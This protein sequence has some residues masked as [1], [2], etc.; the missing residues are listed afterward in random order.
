MKK[1]KYIPIIIIITVLLFS[2]IGLYC[3]YPTINKNAKE[4]NHKLSI[5]QFIYEQTSKYNYVIDKQLKN[6]DYQ[7]YLQI[8]GNK[9]KYLQ[10]QEKSII[11]DFQ[12]Y[13]IEL[14]NEKNIYYYAI[15]TK[16]NKIINNT[17]DHLIDIQTDQKLQD[18]YQYYLQIHFDEYGDISL[19]FQ[20][21]S[22]ENNFSDYEAIYSD[23]YVDNDDEGETQ[24]ELSISKPKNITIT[25]AIPF[26]L[27]HNDTIDQYL[28]SSY[29][30]QSMIYMI[31]YIM[32]CLVIVVLT[33]LLIPFHKIKDNQFFHFISEIKF[34]ILSIIWIFIMYILSYILYDFINLT[35]SNE[36][37]EFYKVFAIEYMASY[38]TALINI[39]LWFIFFMLIAILIYMIK[40]LF[41]KGL[42]TYFL[43]NTCVSWVFKQIKRLINDILH[44]NFEDGTNKILLKIIIFNF[45]LICIISLLFVTGPMIA[46]IDSIII[47]FILKKK[48]EETK[49]DYQI[50][51]NA[52]KQLSNGHFDFEINEDI[53]MF[54]PLKNEFSHIKDGFEKAVSEEVKSQKM[55]TEL[56]SNVSHDLKTPLTSIITYVDLL[57]D[58]QISNQQRH[59]YIHILE[60]NSLRL[61]NLIEDL[62]EVS[63]AN[64]GNV[65]LDLIDVDIV[66]MIK[67][68]ELEYNEQFSEM[69]L[70][71]RSHYSNNKIICNLDSSKTY[72]IIENLFTNITKYA[73]KN[74][75]VYIDILDNDDYVEIVF[76]NISKDEMTFNESE[77]VE[78]FIQGDKSRN[79]SGSG[80]G[81]AIVKSFTEIQGGIF[82]VEIDGD[83]F[84]SIIKFKK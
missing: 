82:K 4:E 52:T 68:I 44:F 74:T 16:S 20:S 35:M 30:H 53:G 64:S 47:F 14:A 61:K 40:Y 59:E 56:I 19:K 26:E 60:R 33:I 51:L 58:E 31:P 25:Y 32:I 41:H 36:I 10:Q 37:Q 12:S 5:Y 66:A 13:E 67:Q 69:G 62:F 34:E 83:L 46:L 42:K 57:K 49:D 63:K 71:I 22:F 6:N 24:G 17:S 2:S 23:T 84:K 38:L 43:E 78:R 1:N 15:D 18:Q 7:Q 76:K 11:K 27:T 3:M 80:L 54:N 73:L 39:G 48:L 79:A 55:K 81:L 77:I 65:Q 75:R 70:D 72:R 45:I 50:L 8:S 21:N 9:T 28:N 29:V